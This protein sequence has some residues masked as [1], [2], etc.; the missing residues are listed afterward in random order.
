MS[1]AFRDVGTT[2]ADT[3]GFTPPE[4]AHFRY[5]ALST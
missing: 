3:I 4:W 1:R 2:T 5:H